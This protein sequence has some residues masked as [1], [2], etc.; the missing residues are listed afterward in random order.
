MIFKRSESTTIYIF[1]H[2]LFI[3]CIYLVFDLVTRSTNLQSIQ[4]T[5]S[6]YF[7]SFF[8]ARCTKASVLVYYRIN[9]LKA[10]PNI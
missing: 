3:P 8:F 9:A 5:L 1:L 7:P 2:I 10:K 4:V 6:M